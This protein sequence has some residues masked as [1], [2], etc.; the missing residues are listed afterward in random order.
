MEYKQIINNIGEEIN[1]AILITPYIFE[2]DRGYFFENWNKKIFKKN[3][4][5]CEFVQDNISISNKNVLRGLHYQLNPSAQ[6]KL[7]TTISGSIYDVIV[8]LRKSSSTYKTWASINLNSNN[9]KLLWIPSGFAHGFLTLE[10][11]TIVNYKVDNFWDKNLERSL[12]WNDKDLKI[13]WPILNSNLPSTSHKD[14]IA[15]SFKEIEKNGDVF[16]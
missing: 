11:K 14:A 3:I 13:D 16:L 10:D 12:I 2:D 1:G 7:I 15:K 8:D 5:S 4:G 6:S 9:K